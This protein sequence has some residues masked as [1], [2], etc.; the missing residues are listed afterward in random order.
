[1]PKVWSFVLISW[2]TAHKKTYAESPLNKKV[3]LSMVQRNL[4]FINR[5]TVLTEN[6]ST[7]LQLMHVARPNIAT[8]S[9]SQEQRVEPHVYL[10]G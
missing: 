9:R 8:N 5:N 1:M 2:S 10:M 4:N 6:L 7:Q 3:S